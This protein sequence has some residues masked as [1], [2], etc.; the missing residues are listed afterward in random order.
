M[1][2]RPEEADV[3]ALAQ[4]TVN[5]A[6]WN[7]ATPPP[8]HTLFLTH[9]VA[10][11]PYRRGLH[12]FSC[13]LVVPSSLESDLSRVQTLR[14]I[15]YENLKICVIDSESRYLWVAERMAH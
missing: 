3:A 6:G 5:F 11:I 4:A 14:C 9:S 7:T 12:A 2:V 13:G 15:L 8:S 10:I 1:D